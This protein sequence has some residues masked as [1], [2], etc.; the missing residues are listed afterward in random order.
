MA[1][2]SVTKKRGTFLNIVLAFLVF[3]I[4]IETGSLFFLNLPTYYTVLTAVYL[5]IQ[6]IGIYGLYTWKK[7]GIFVFIIANIIFIIEH[8]AFEGWKNDILISPVEVG[9]LLWAYLQ[10]KGL[11][12]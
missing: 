12:K 2:A 11:Y 9:L 3:Q 1:N 6:A 7:W 10:K 8:L 4:V 5:F